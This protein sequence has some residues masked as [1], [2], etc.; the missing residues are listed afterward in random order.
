MYREFA[1]SEQMSDAQQQRPRRRRCAVDN[2][3]NDSHRWLCHCNGLRFVAL[4]QLCL[5][6]WVHLCI[7]RVVM[8]WVEVYVI[9]ELCMYL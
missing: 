1:S 2:A 5:F 9:F 6:E 8:K 3:V 7:S 4:F